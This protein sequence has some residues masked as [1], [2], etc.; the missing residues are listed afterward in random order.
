MELELEGEGRKG[1]G[2]G[3][4]RGTTARIAHV[5]ALHPVLFLGQRLFGGVPGR[6]LQLLVRDEPHPGQ[7]RQGRGQGV[8]TRALTSHRPHDEGPR[9]DLLVVARPR[10]QGPPVVQRAADGHALVHALVGGAAHRHLVHVRRHQ[11]RHRVHVTVARVRRRGGGGRLG[12]RAAEAGH[13]LQVP[14]AG[15]ALELLLLAVGHGEEELLPEPGVVVLEVGARAHVQ[16]QRLVQL[17]LVQVLQ[18]H[19]QHAVLA[20]RQHLLVR[21]LELE[22]APLAGQE[23]VGEQHDGALAA[24]HALDDR[25]GDGGAHGEV[26]V[27]QAQLEALVAVLQPGGQLPHHEVLVQAAVGHEGVV[28]TVL[29]LPATARGHLEHAPAELGEAEH[30]QQVAVHVHCDHDCQPQHEEHGHRDQHG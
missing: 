30:G 6:V 25:L 22:L 11:V 28:G 23:V 7:G 14:R 5:N 29:V 2:K 21:R 13:V 15:Q 24:L 3:K 26:A 27:V 9:R 10:P 17:A 20:L 12:G 19:E 8:L 16:P 18:Q 1:E 4:G